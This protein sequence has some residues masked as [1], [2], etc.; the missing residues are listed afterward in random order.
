MRAEPIGTISAAGITAK[1]IRN[2]LVV[3]E[4]MLRSVGIISLR[5]GWGLMIEIER[6]P[7]AK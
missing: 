2:D 7:T 4:T 1:R 5:K 6:I 3:Q